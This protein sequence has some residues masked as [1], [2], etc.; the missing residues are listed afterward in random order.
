M[1]SMLPKYLS[2]NIRWNPLHIWTQIVIVVI[3]EYSMFNLKDTEDINQLCMLALAKYVCTT[4][5]WDMHAHIC[6]YTYAERVNLEKDRSQIPVWCLS[7]QFWVKDNGQ[8]SLKAG[9]LVSISHDHKCVYIID[10]QL[11]VSVNYMNL[12]WNTMTYWWII[13]FYINKCEP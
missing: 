1:K 8:V 10:H 13:S 4:S 12:I 3:V 5:A 9:R 7:T 6:K 11:T 2:Y